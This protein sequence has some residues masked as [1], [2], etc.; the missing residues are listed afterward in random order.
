MK[1]MIAVGIIGVGI[2]AAGCS[3]VQDKWFGTREDCP[4]EDS[5]YPEYDENG[6]HIERGERPAYGGDKDLSGCNTNAEG[7]CEDPVL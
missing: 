6:W 2:L 1:K 3:P 5:C 7:F 4:A